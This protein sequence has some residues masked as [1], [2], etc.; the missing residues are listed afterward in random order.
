MQ[1]DLYIRRC[2][3]LA[4]NGIRKVAPNPMVG[5]VIVC[6]NKIIGEGYHSFFGGPHAEVIAINNAISN[7][8]EH[9]FNRSSLFVNL[10]PCSHFGKT[11]PCANLI[12]E[13]KIERVVICNRDPNPLVAGSGIELLK[14]SGIEVIEGLLS[15]EGFELNKRFFTFHK[16]KRPYVILKFAESNDG[17]IAHEIPSLDNR[18]ISN[19]LSNQLVH[20]WRSEEQAI[21]VGTNTAIIDNPSLT[22][23][24]VSGENPIRILIDK[25]LK[26]PLS[27]NVFN[28]EST[29][30]VF[31][32]T[33]NEEHGHIQFI[34]CS[35]GE[36]FIQ[37]LL[38]LLYQRQ[39]LSLFV[40]GGKNLIQQFIDLKLCDELRV[41]TSP[42][43]IS[44]GLSSPNFSGISSE[45]IELGEDLITIYRN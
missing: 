45:K 41:I 40:E 43:T 4:A 22:V 38:T 16:K 18:K 35:F 3:F 32:Q 11:P 27:H 10:E 21:M 28:K 2:L 44:K 30:W 20:H 23:R 31:N 19:A 39:I 17:F 5:C 29:T 6:D 8:H 24:N 25:D 1:H 7:G 37:E 15:E 34:K 42:H 36:N 33:K 12:I 9:L 13:K 26:V 14:K